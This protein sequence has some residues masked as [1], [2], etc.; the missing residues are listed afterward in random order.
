MTTI[1]D[2]KINQILPN[3]RRDTHPHRWV[4]KPL[5]P[6]VSRV[7]EISIIVLIIIFQALNWLLS[8][9]SSSSL[10]IYIITHTASEYPSIGV[11]KDK[12]F[13]KDKIQ[14]LIKLTRYQDLL[15]DNLYVLLSFTVHVIK[16]MDEFVYYLQLKSRS[17]LVICL[18]A[19]VGTSVVEFVHRVLVMTL[20][21]AHWILLTVLVTTQRVMFTEY[22]SQRVFLAL[23]I[24]ILGISRRELDAGQPT[25]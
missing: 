14:V 9:R 3:S 1:M 8:S 2:G 25:I 12:L 18:F 11:I 19:F 21:N 4:Q 24:I 7:E 22:Y 15:C 10:L 16:R 17:H 6:N 13:I 23:S 20:S 5:P